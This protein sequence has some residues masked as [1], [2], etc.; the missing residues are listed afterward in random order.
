MT[1]HSHTSSNAHPRQRLRLSTVQPAQSEVSSHSSPRGPRKRS[2]STPRLSRQRGTSVQLIPPTPPHPAPRLRRNAS[3]SVCSG[4]SGQ[5]LK[6][7][8]EGPRASA[9][10]LRERTAPA[11]AAAAP[12]ARSRGASE[13]RSRCWKPSR[14]SVARPLPKFARGPRRAGQPREERSRPRRRR[15][16]GAGSLERS[17]ARGA[18]SPGHPREVQPGLLS[19]QLLEHRG[20]KKKRQGT[21][22]PGFSGDSRHFGEPRE[23]R[24][25]PLASTLEGAQRPAASGRTLRRPQPQARRGLRTWGSLSRSEPSAARGAVRRVPEERER[26]QQPTGRPL[27]PVHAHPTRQARSRRAPLGALVPRRL[28]PRVPA[29]RATGRAGGVLG[30]VRIGHWWPSGCS[31]GTS[32]KAGVRRSRGGSAQGPPRSKTRGGGRSA[33]EPERRRPAGPLQR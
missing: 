20:R 8:Q 29:P 32:V 31:P 24:H 2:V 7:S 28:L 6:C 10:R 12:P 3:R 22:R 18:A 13:L 33:Q 27:T 1:P 14:A 4:H 23:K 26:G 9:P 17:R 19:P 30:G 21:A 11:A 25:F 5:E 16:R 15:R